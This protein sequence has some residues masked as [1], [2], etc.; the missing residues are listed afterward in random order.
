MIQPHVQP[1]RIDGLNT[2]KT[3]DAPSLG[4]TWWLP[5]LHIVTVWP[6][7]SPHHLFPPPCGPCTPGSAA[8]ICH[9]SGSSHDTFL[10]FFC[11]GYRYSAV[12]P[13]QLQCGYPYPF[14]IDFKIFSTLKPYKTECF[15]T[16]GRKMKHSNKFLPLFG[17]HKPSVLTFL[18][19]SACLIL[20]TV[21]TVS[22]NPAVT[23]FVAPTNII[24]L[25]LSSS[26]YWFKLLLS[27]R[28]FLYILNPRY[29]LSE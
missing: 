8:C 24:C 19:K 29:T 13:Q 6:R 25:A 15:S 10:N 16:D 5:S 7:G 14:L 20:L 17:G 18:Q 21:L 26:N 12:S 9:L 2:S 1:F 27:W 3:A 22:S 11:P 4:P 28:R 23:A